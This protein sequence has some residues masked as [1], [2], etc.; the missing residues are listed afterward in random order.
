MDPVVVAQNVLNQA[1]DKKLPVCIVSIAKEL[2]ISIL[3]DKSLEPVDGQLVYEDNQPQILINPDRSV[4]NKRYTACLML[5][6]HTL[7]H[8]QTMRDPF[9][10]NPA[11]SV[12]PKVQ[13]ANL[14]VAEIIIPRQ[15]VHFYANVKTKGLKE[16]SDIFAVS[17]TAMRIRLERLGVV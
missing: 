5:A 1:W 12:D 15:A 6:H 9:Q 16:L 7:G 11:Y 2:G 4:E 17:Q 14:F 3:Y 10:V 13:D 8:G